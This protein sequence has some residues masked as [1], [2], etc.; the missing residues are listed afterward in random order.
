MLISLN[1]FSQRNVINVDS[2]IKTDNYNVIKN[3]K[4]GEGE[5]NVLDLWIAD[6]NVNSPLIIYIHGGGFSSGNKESA[7]RKNSFNRIKKF[8]DN[9]ISFATINYRFRNN[10]DGII[11]IFHL[12]IFNRFGQKVFAIND[13]T[14]K[15]N[16]K[17]NGEKL[18]PQVFDFYLEIS[19]IGAKTLFHKGNITLIR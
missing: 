7:Y 5:R 12:E 18:P 19:C 3:L 8:I 10:E 4:Y 15:W 16:G 13:K 1:L 9:G 6:E 2:I 11:T 14:A 17:F